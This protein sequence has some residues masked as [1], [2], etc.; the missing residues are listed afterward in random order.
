MNNEV[1]NFGN[2]SPEWV[3]Q[4]RGTAK[5]VADL[6]KHFTFTSEEIQEMNE[7]LKDTRMSITPYLLKLIE[8]DENQKIKP[9]DPIWLQYGPSKMEADLSDTNQ[10]WE[11]PEEMFAD[12]LDEGESSKDL[13]QKKYLGQHK[14]PDKVV[15]RIAHHCG[16]YCR[17]CYER[18]RTL[19]KDSKIAPKKAKEQAVQYLQSHPEVREVILT[20]GDP[21][22]LSDNVLEEWIKTFSELNTI[23][24]VRIHTRMLAQNPYRATPELI[25]ILKNNGVKWINVQV[26]HPRE[27]TDDFIKALKSIREQGILV[28]TENPIIHG[29]NDNPE[30]LVEL[31][32]LCRKNGIQ[33]HHWFHSMPGTPAEMRV[34]VERAVLL[35]Q[36]TKKLL[37]IRWNTS[38]LGDLVIPHPDGKRTVPWEEIVIDPKLPREKWGTNNFH[39]TIDTNGNPIVKFTSWNPNSTELQEY[40]DPNINLKDFNR[41]DFTDLLK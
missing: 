13:E 35:F 38:E 29:L 16:A 40:S 10:M 6:Q 28:K 8:T 4:L 19:E 20:G 39:F 3:V 33:N 30:T 25:E 14:Y 5:T 36:K 21:L 1:L 17:F 41:N 15:I 34:S 32:K 7:V 31:I 27:I 26:N 37:N 22:A 23:E 2:N 9:G 11:R 12:G 24:S 18:E